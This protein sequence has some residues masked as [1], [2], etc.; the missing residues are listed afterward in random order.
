MTVNEP[1]P[2]AS[3]ERPTPEAALQLSRRT[4]LDGERIE[5][6]TL[7]ADLGIGRST[8]YRWFGDR[9]RLIGETVWTLLD[10]SIQRAESEN[11]D[12]RGAARLRA[13][14]S[15]INRD[16]SASRPLRRLLT[17]EPEAALRVLTTKHGGVQPRVIR[18]LE[19]RIS[20]EREHEPIAE[21]VEARDLAYALVRLNEGFLYA[22]Q[23]TDTPVDLDA[24]DKI[25]A[26]LL[27]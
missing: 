22:D 8:L 3:G 23:I 26:A 6:R 16:I 25:V 15:R 18:Y 21:G 20:E 17:A 9:D 12:L 11:A 5:M 10:D 19:K 4:F 2:S 24:L 14:I 1:A 7:A 27:R 13:V